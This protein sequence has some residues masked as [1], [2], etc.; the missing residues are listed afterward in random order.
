M[1]C[2][3]YS[4]ELHLWYS[5]WEKEKEGI[6]WPWLL[7]FRLYAVAWPLQSCLDTSPFL[8]N[9]HSGSPR[10]CRIFHSVVLAALAWL[11]PLGFLPPVDLA[12]W[13]L[14]FRWL[15]RSWRPGIGLHVFVTV[16]QFI[17]VLNATGSPTS[18]G[19]GFCFLLEVSLHSTIG[20]SAIDNPP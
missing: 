3:E 13:L 11:R 15:W 1:P 9:K 6:K 10:S 4:L 2:P 20:N 7:R 8:E 14:S 16:W 19:P 17:K 18:P 12:Y 5:E